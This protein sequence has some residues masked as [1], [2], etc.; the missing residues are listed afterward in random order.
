[1]CSQFGFAFVFRCWHSIGNGFSVGLNRFGLRITFEIKWKTVFDM[2]E[3]ENICTSSEALS[4]LSAGRSE[5][6]DR[7]G[8]GLAVRT[9]SSAP[10][11]VAAAAALPLNRVANCPFRLSEQRHRNSLARLH[12]EEIFALARRSAA[13]HPSPSRARVH[14]A[15]IYIAQSSQH[16]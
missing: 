14:P 2:I 13:S 9:R 3:Y 12:S 6:G 5:R 7:L 8:S 10:R 11:G 4:F 16:K 15:R 1:M